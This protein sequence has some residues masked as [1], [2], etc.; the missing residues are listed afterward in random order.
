M[1]VCGVLDIPVDEDILRSAE[2][3][4]SGAAGDVQESG[5]AMDDDASDDVSRIA[6]AAAAECH[7]QGQT[8]GV[9]HSLDCLCIA[10][11]ASSEGVQ[12]ACYCLMQLLILCLSCS[13]SLSFVCASCATGCYLLLP[14]AVAHV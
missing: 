14:A 11:P 6:A 7:S 2:K 9:L 3:A 1:Q 13:S 12:T 5:S 4:A 10:L 8:E